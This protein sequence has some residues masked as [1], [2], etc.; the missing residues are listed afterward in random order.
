MSRWGG[1][2]PTLHL[3]VRGNF[4]IAPYDVA[5]PPASHSATRR[6]PTPS[7]HVRGR[8]WASV[9]HQDWGDQSNNGGG[10]R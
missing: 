1:K 6:H 8:T 5:L 2:I 4:I 7:L 9:T 10:G 3:S